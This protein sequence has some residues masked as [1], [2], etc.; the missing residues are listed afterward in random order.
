[1]ELV[2]ILDNSSEAVATVDGK[3]YTLSDDHESRVTKMQ[4]KFD[5]IKDQMKQ[6]QDEVK[7][8]LNE[9]IKITS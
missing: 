4:A 3:L 1:M 8:I 9:I 6:D 7:S 2:S 5:K